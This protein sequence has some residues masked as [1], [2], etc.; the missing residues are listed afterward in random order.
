M[1]GLEQDVVCIMEHHPVVNL[2]ETIAMIIQ[3]PETIAQGHLKIQVR[4]NVVK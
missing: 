4:Q 1:I 3:E 2:G